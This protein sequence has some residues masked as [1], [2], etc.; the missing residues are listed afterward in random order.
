MAALVLWVDQVYFLAGYVLNVKR[1]LILGDGLKVER[2]IPYLLK[3]LQ[4]I[5]VS[6]L[7]STL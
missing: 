7:V 1:I 3:R 6:L 2:L 4:H 5:G